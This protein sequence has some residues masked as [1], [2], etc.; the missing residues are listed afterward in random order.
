MIRTGTAAMLA[1]GGAVVLAGVTAALGR[2]AGGTSHHPAALGPVTPLPASPTPQSHGSTH[3]PSPAPSSP[4][5]TGGTVIGST[6]AGAG[7]AGQAVHRPVH[8]AA[9]VDGAPVRG[10]VR[11]VQRRLQPTPAV[12]CSSTRQ[13]S[14]SSARA[15]AASTTPGPVKCCKGPP[16]APL[17]SIP[18]RVAAGQLRV[19]G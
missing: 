17:Q 3:S 4:G 9:G 2:A 19:D 6:L 5:S 16:P 11:C 13:T 7:W 1:A 12:R 18:V 14:S 10:D 15:T 8:R